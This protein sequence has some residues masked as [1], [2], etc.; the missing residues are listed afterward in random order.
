MEGRVLGQTHIPL[1]Y[2]PTFV[3]GGAREKAMFQR[4][5]Q[6]ADAAGVVLW[7]RQPRLK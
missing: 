3:H 1:L 2:V 4:E 6:D 7:T 5:E